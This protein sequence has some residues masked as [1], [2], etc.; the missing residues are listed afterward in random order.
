MKPLDWMLLIISLFNMLT[1]M[2]GVVY[3][4]PELYTL[5]AFQ[6]RMTF[7]FMWIIVPIMIIAWRI[8]G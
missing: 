8:W 6:R 4:P 7:R 5:P 3:M 2:G 1:F